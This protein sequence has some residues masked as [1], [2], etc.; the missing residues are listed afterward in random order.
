MNLS[1]QSVKAVADFYKPRRVIVIHDDLDLG[2]GV[3]KFKKGGGSGGHNGLKSIDSLMG[4][5]YERI[6]IG[7]GRGGFSGESAVTDHVLGEFSA[8]EKDGLEKILDYSLTAAKELLKSDIETVSQ[9][10]STKKGIL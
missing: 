10:F 8:E 6:R 3:V 5:D 7:I 2:F 4:S 9:K 1:G